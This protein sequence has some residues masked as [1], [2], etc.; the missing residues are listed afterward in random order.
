[1]WHPFHLGQTGSALCVI[2]IIDFETLKLQTLTNDFLE[3]NL[4]FLDALRCCIEHRY[5]II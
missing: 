3:L 2:A 5:K 4:A 1:M